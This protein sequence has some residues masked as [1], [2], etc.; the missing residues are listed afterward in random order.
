[1]CDSSYTVRYGT[2]VGNGSDS[3]HFLYMGIELSSVL[4]IIILNYDNVNYLIS[5]PL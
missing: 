4:G 3:V 1:M 5:Y 2:I